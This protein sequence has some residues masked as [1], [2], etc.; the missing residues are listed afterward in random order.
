MKIVEGL[1]CCFFH[2][3]CEDDCKDSSGD[4]G[5]CVSCDIIIGIGIIT[6]HK[7][8]VDERINSF[9]NNW[10]LPEPVPAVP[11][12]SV[13]VVS[14]VLHVVPVPEYL[15]TVVMVRVCGECYVRS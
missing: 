3:D 7:Y 6:R 12:D 8:G 14:A 2:L 15:A 9:K 4:S 1:L 5:C 13:P 11:V 10:K